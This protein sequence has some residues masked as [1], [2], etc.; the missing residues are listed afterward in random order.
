MQEKHSHSRDYWIVEGRQSVWGDRPGNS[1]NLL[2]VIK[3][4]WYGTTKIGCV[5][6]LSVSVNSGNRIPK[7]SCYGVLLKGL[8]S[9]IHSKMPLE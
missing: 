5:G 7:F 2:V 1:I 9:Q 6:N 8:A 4:S 3:W